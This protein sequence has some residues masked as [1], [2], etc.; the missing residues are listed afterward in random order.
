MLE[1]RQK[2][3]LT[4]VNAQLAPFKY[5]SVGETYL[6][7]I[8][9]YERM[10][11]YYLEYHN[12]PSQNVFDGYCEVSLYD[13]VLLSVRRNSRF[14]SHL[15]R[16]DHVRKTSRRRPTPTSS[17]LFNLP[18]FLTNR[19]LLRAQTLKM[20]SLINCLCYYWWSCLQDDESWIFGFAK[21]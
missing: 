21:S 13:E 10:A 6:H 7:S 15:F 1:A 2:F 16:S 3:H 11:G 8:D 19:Y 14:P 4:P 17:H 5:S 9:Q 18:P 20:H 12:K